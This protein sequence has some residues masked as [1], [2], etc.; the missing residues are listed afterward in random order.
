MIE[1]PPNI[2]ISNFR[3][4]EVGVPFHMFDFTIVGLAVAAAG[5]CFVAL[6]GWR[7]IPSRQASIAMGDTL[8]IEDYMTE[9]RVSEDSRFAEG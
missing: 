1:T 4:E 9:V 8:D 2:I 3:R 5:I 7:L 6:V